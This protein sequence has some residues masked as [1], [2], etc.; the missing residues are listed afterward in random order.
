MRWEVAEYRWSAS[1]DEIAGLARPL[2]PQGLCRF[3][4][5]SA[6]PPSS[7]SPELPRLSA[8]LLRAP[9]STTSPERPRLLRETGGPRLRPL[10]LKAPPPPHPL[11]WHCICRRLSK[12][13]PSPCM[14]PC[15]VSFL[16]TLHRLGP[17]ASLSYVW[18]HFSHRPPIPALFLHRFFLALP[19]C[20]PPPQLR[21][22][23]R[24]PGYP[25]RSGLSL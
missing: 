20:T 3:L 10:L 2:D 15:P 13:P 24:V 25:H 1:L 7:G 6:G 4:A 17:S 9:P 12:T 23:A 22:A 18:S 5:P 11:R 21:L 16:F 8:A 19:L 14:H